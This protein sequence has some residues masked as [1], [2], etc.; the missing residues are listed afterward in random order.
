[1]GALIRTYGG[2]QGRAAVNDGLLGH[3]KIYYTDGTAQTITTD[4]TWQVSQ[5]VPFSGTE[6]RN[7][8]GD[9]TVL[10]EEVVYNKLYHTGIAGSAD[11]ENNIYSWEIGN[12]I[13]GDPQ[14]VKMGDLW[15][16]NIF[17]YSGNSP[18]YDTF[19]VSKDMVNWTLWNSSEGV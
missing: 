5:S 11:T 16:M 2:G 13:T 14:V 8:E 15:V 9:I 7:S 1:M 18:A 17:T 3:I 19:A 6:E 10:T 4:K 12:T